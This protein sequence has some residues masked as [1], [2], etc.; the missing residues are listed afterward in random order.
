MDGRITHAATPE[1]RISAVCR[2]L[3]FRFS[4]PVPDRPDYA[5]LTEWLQIYLEREFL[6]VRLDES[7]QAQTPERGE[8]LRTLLI[9][10]EAR[11]AELKL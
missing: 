7:H 4:R 6:I 9:K 11:I 2:S 3:I 8:L 5:D 1:A 10:A